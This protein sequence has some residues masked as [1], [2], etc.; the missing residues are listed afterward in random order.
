MKTNKELA[1]A[2]LRRAGELRAQKT[3]RRRRVY[4]ALAVAAG[5]VLVVGLSIAMPGL[6]PETVT[7]TDAAASGS[8]TLMAGGVAGSYVVVGVIAFA[9][10]VGVTL[11]CLWLRRKK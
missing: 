5:L 3:K 7:A 4:S 6:L 9:L 1:D 11:L 10:G 2:V 8:A